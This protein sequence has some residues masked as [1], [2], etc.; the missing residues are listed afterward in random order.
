MLCIFYNMRVL[1]S[2]ECELC[3]LRGRSPLHNSRP[4]VPLVASMTW[5]DPPLLSS[6][7]DGLEGMGLL[8]R[9]GPYTD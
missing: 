9:L 7:R 1:H 3:T 5:A 2:G 8:L 6:W 4:A